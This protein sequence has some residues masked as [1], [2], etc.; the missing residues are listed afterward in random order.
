MDFPTC[1]TPPR[2]AFSFWRIGC[3]RQGRMIGMFL[4]FERRIPLRTGR[5]KGVMNRGYGEKYGRF[6]LLYKANPEMKLEGYAHAVGVSVATISLWVT[7]YRASIML[8]PLQRATG[9]PRKAVAHD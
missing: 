2:I 7:K 3:E 4:L 6:C 9:R 1:P 8:P 5:P